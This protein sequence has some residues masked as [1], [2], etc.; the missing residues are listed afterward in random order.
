MNRKCFL[1]FIFLVV[2]Q[3][4]FSQ[5][6][7]IKR[8]PIWGIAKMTFLTSSFQLV[9]DYYGHYLGFEEAFFYNS[10]IGKVISF[11]VN[12][13]QF[14]EFIEDSHAKEK[15]RLVSV[16]LET[17]EVEQMRCYL[18]AKGIKVPSSITVDGAGNETIVVHDPSGVAIEFINF[19]SNSLHKKSEGKF[20][21]D[22]RISKRLH[23]V[24]IVTKNVQEDNKF[25]EEVLGCKMIW[26][27][28][29]EGNEANIIYAYLVFPDCAEFLEYFVSNDPNVSHPCFLIEDMQETIYTLKERQ[30]VNFNDKPIIGKGKRWI[31]NMKN[32]DGTRVEFS[33]AHTVY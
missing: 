31:L 22:Q 8:P 32:T 25:Y 9:K 24:G 28:P 27:F 2:L 3:F 29:E 4:S 19:K 20:L 14:L 10:E 17:T 13:R 11:K 7:E 26:R 33:E 23:H 6:V 18:K 21:S 15:S 12:D 1:L 16:S 30:N 5:S